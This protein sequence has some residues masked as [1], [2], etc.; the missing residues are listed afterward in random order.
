MKVSIIIPCFNVADHI[1]DALMSALSQ[2]YS[3]TEVICVDN[4]SMDCTCEYIKNYVDRGEVTLLHESEPGASAA[5]NRGW[6]NSTGEWIQFL[7]ADDMILPEK[8]AHQV[9][10]IEKNPESPFI[11]SATT[12]TDLGTG[13]SRP[14]PVHDEAW[15]GLLQNKLGITTANLFSR[16]ALEKVGGWDETLK[17]SQE[18]DLMFR[19]MQLN[20][21]LIL[22]QHA[23]NSI[24]QSRAT[25]SISSE[26]VQGNKNRYLALMARITSYLQKERPEIYAELDSSWFQEMFMRIYLNAVDGGRGSKKYHKMIIPDGFEPERHEFIPSWFHMLYCR[27]GYDV[28]ESVRSLKPTFSKSR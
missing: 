8:I 17:S 1:D 16:S 19:I 11:A 15:K 20:D 18:Y 22:D 13:H 7:D 27:L 10:L 14:W 24:I 25:G 9:R 21:H 12:K 28:A 5:R 23:E 2:S 3:D 4:G 6:R 26:D